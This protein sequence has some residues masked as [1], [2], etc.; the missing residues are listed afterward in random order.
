MQSNYQSDLILGVSDSHD[1][2]V[3]LVRGGKILAAIN[4]ERFNRKKMTGGIPLC[5][6][7]EIWHIAGVKPEEVTRVGLAG[8]ASL[9]TPPLNNDFSDDSGGI[10]AGQKIAEFIDR[11]PGGD[12]LLANPAANAAYRGLIS[13]A[14]SGRVERIRAH[15]KEVG[16]KADLAAYGHHDCHIASAYFTSGA[17]QGLLI[18]NDGFGDGRCCMVAVSDAGDGRL[19]KLSSNSFFN[20]LGVYYNYVTNFCGFKKAHHAGKTTGL[21][22][23]GDPEKTLAIFESMIAWDPALGI[24]V[25]HGKLFRNCL[26]DIRNRLAGVSREDAAAGIQKHFENILTAMVG[27]YVAQTGKRSVVLTGGIHA[28]VK[29]NQRIADVPGVERVFVFPNMGDG[30]LA[31]GAAYLAQA[32]AYP[33]ETRPSALDDVY[34]G[35]S[36]PESSIAD[37]LRDAGVAFTKPE[38]LA[39]SVAQHLRDNKIVARCDGRM[40]YGPR[41]LGNRSILYPATNPE[42]NKWL[43]HQ[44]KRTE[45]MPFAPVIRAADA[46]AFFKGIDDKTAHTAEFMTI[47]YDVTERCKREAPA[48]VHVDGTARPQVLR[49]EINPG[50]YDILD[51]YH[52][53]T[54]LS[55]LVNTSFNI[56]EEPIVC[57][58][59]DALKAFYESNLDTMA[60]GP[61]LITNDRKA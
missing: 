26:Y 24:Y 3:A 32:A 48:V 57:S 44:L 46:T 2:G 20:S 51:E 60:L 43:N 41:A 45:F 19:R 8:T 12:F 23:F 10:S 22:A 50:Y 21:A 17:P 59:Q 37:C 38:N 47:T 25:N 55:V 18:S 35:P 33:D 61:F 49:R 11:A 9:G 52:K 30:G 14:G 42:V 13:V 4:E 15:L 1:A 34:L 53:L 31:L 39:A 28:N 29:V 16:V 27:H 40:E 56:H 36:Y 7:Q 54:G 58:P 6:L 5:C